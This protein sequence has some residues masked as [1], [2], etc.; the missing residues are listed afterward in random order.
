MFNR[1]WLGEQIAGYLKDDT[2][3]PHLDTFIDIAAKRVSQ[4]LECWEMEQEIV[5]TI[6]ISGRTSVDGGNATGGG[7]GLVLDGGDA[8]KADDVTPPGNYL[9]LPEGTRRVLGVQVLSNGI[10]R[11]LRSVGRHEANAYKGTGSPFYYYVEG[12][13]IRPL[14]VRDGTYKAQILRE[15]VIPAGT[16]EVDALNAYPFV[17]LNAALSEAYDWKQNEAMAL[18]Y[19]Q[20]WLNEANEIA[21]NYRNARGGEVLEVRSI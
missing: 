13:Q 4:V 6:Q 12:K 16:N 10:Y 11:N 5:N 1:Q 21:G 18:R 8:F 19:E 14:P 20:K 15:V 7:G 3:G 2:L 9:T 17:F